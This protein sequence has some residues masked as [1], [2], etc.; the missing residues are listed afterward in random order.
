MDFSQTV[1][2]SNVK[3][4]FNENKD[5]FKPVDDNILGYKLNINRPSWFEQWKKNH[6][7]DEIEATVFT[8][9]N[10]EEIFIKMYKKCLE[11]LTWTKGARVNKGDPVDLLNY[12]QSYNDVLNDIV[13]KTVS[14]EYVV[15]SDIDTEIQNDNEEEYDFDPE[16]QNDNEEEYDFDPENSVDE[17]DDN[18][19]QDDNDE[20]III[21]KANKEKYEP[22][23]IKHLIKDKMDFYGFNECGIY[24]CCFSVTALEKDGD[25]ESD[26]D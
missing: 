22:I 9:K 6:A 1:T 11:K 25:L 17:E 2:L 23:L 3:K 10:E 12:L 7:I 18:V 8:G 24:D 19:S 14:G 20:F 16:I 21:N 4:W 15:F 13:R 5:K 26:N